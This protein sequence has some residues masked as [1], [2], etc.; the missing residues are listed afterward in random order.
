MAN[1]QQKVATTVSPSE[2]TP[3]VDA[4]T[5][6]L[7]RDPTFWRFHYADPMKRAKAQQEYELQQVLGQIAGMPDIWEEDT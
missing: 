1:R 5:P 3:L 4:T 6:G 2:C 7:F